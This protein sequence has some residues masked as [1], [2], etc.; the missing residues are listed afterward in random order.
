MM[1]K[2]AGTWNPYKMGIPF[3]IIPKKYTFKS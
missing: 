1:I 3:Q 2:I